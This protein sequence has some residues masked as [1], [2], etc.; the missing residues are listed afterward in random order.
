[1]RL[2]V[3][4]GSLNRVWA[5]D[6]TI[7]VTGALRDGF[8]RVLGATYQGYLLLAP[9]L[10]AE[11]VAIFPVRTA[12]TVIAVLV[13]GCVALLAAFVIAASAARVPSP[14]LR[15]LL[16]LAVVLLPVGRVEVVGALANLQWP[17]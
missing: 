2:A 5:E 7:F 14:A 13:A 9:R 16:G 4:G 6:G 12:G 10:L 17:L 1:M 3:V 15:G 8:P 11:V